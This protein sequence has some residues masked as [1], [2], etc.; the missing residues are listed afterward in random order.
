MSEEDEEE[1]RRKEYEARRRK[2]IAQLAESEGA[3]YYDP[4][5]PVIWKQY[6]IGPVPFWRRVLWWFVPPSHAKMIQIVRRLN[7]QTLRDVTRFFR[8]SRK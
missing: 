6:V 3:C 8:P 5:S 1:K 2:E 4:E 7:H